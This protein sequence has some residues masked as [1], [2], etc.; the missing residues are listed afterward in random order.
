MS[1]VPTQTIAPGVEIPV[2]GLGVFRAGPGEGTRAAVRA[3]LRAGYR[4]IDTASVYGNEQEVGQALRDSGI[5]REDVFLTTKLWNEHHGAQ[6]ARAAL[7]RSLDALGV[8][9][10]DLYLVHWPVPELR[11]ESW[12][13]LEAI[14]AAGRARAIGVSNYTVRHLR[15]LLA[16]CQIRPAL[17]QVEVHPFL[18]Q[19]ELR[20]FCRREGIAVAA[21]CP[22]TRGQRLDDPVVVEVARAL[23]RS[24]AQVLLRWGIEE[25]LIVLPKSSNLGRIQENAQ[26][27][28]LRL[29]AAHRARLAALD[30]GGRVAW[31]PTP[32]P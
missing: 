12:R 7:E 23:G 24:P 28:D 11:A 3:A 21:Y 9:Q 26:I 8:E 15:E 10:V 4:H 27:F 13:A 2:L 25:G 14:V 6:A 30:C 32:V 29:S 18:Q 20:A 5:P 1:P 17:N 31:D 16:D 19:R 22:L